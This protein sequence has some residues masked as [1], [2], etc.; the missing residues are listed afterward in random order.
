MEDF[1]LKKAILLSVSLGVLGVTSPVMSDLSVKADGTSQ[2]STKDPNI[3]YLTVVKQYHIKDTLTTEHP[4][5]VIEK[6]SVDLRKSNVLFFPDEGDF[7]SS[8]KSVVINPASPHA[9]GVDYTQEPQ[10]ITNIAPL[11]TSNKKDQVSESHVA[12]TPEPSAAQVTPSLESQTEMVLPKITPSENNL[13][14]ESHERA[15]ASPV[16]PV[17]NENEDRL[18]SVDQENA[19]NH[20]LDASND[21]IHLGS[22]TNTVPNSISSDSGVNG[23]LKQVSKSLST[24]SS[25]Q[26]D[27]NTDAP[28]T[29]NKPKQTNA[30]KESN[31]LHN[32]DTKSTENQTSTT[33]KG[34]NQT[35]ATVKTGTVSSETSVSTEKQISADQQNQPKPTNDVKQPA[36]SGVVNTPQVDKMAVD[37]NSHLQSTSDRLSDNNQKVSVGQSKDKSSRKETSSTEQ[38][39]LQGIDEHGQ[40][41]FSKVLNLTKKDATSFQ[42]KNIEFYGYDLTDNELNEETKTFILHYRAKTVTFHIINVDEQG[43]T[44]SKETFQMAFGDQ[45]TYTPKDISGYQVN[46]AAKVLKADNL[47]PDNVTFMYSKLPDK[48]PINDQDQPK[49]HE[50]ATGRAHQNTLAEKEKVTDNHASHTDKSDSKLPQTGESHSFLGILSGFALLIGMMSKKLFK[51]NI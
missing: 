50:K 8:K 4:S 1:I 30:T 23:P 38:Y 9:I 36:K 41:L 11:E 43:K 22:Q 44:L 27:T 14:D 5:I 20:N 39:S 35:V 48:Q 26:I 31:V 21:Q 42:T 32:E 2:S 10:D 33:Q 29:D 49:A 19:K 37:Q 24:V 51:R 40:K 13:N 17:E 7:I 18:Q 15:T 47:L 45:K 3:I 6:Y 12:S 28:T 34:T 25:P 46:N 16:K